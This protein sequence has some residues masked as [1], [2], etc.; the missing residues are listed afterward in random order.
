MKKALIF[1]L[2]VL[3]GL[4]AV[5]SIMDRDG[6]YAVEKRVWKLQQEFDAIA[7]EP[8]AI[9]DLKYDEVAQG[10]QTVIQEYPDSKLTP[11]LH[12]SL[13]RLYA[14]KQDY[15]RAREQFDLVIQK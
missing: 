13:G 9:P 14:L 10:F 1:Y 4:F 6:E 2:V 7:R 5:L 15:G 8:E 3:V 11:L 12:T